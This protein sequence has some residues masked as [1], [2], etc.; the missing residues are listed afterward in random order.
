MKEVNGNKY[1]LTTYHLSQ[2]AMVMMGNEQIHLLLDNDEKVSLK[3]KT[4]MPSMETKMHKRLYEYVYVIP[5]NDLSKLLA[6][7]VKDVRVEAMMN[8]FDHSILDDVSTKSMFN[9]VN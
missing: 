8:G 4:I 9:C 5:D 1:L 3:I 7:D 2:G 6:H